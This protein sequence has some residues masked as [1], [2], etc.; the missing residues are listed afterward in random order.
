MGMRVEDLLRHFLTRAAP[1]AAGY[2]GGQVAGE[3][4]KR[5]R[6]E[7]ATATAREEADRQRR[8]ERESA[9]DRRRAQQDQTEAEKR[10]YEAANPIIGPNG[11]RFSTRQ[12]LEEFIRSQA[13]INASVSAAH[14]A[15]PSATESATASN[16]ALARARAAAMGSAKNLYTA[17]SGATPAYVRQQLRAQYPNLPEGE[18]QG[19]ALEAHAWANKERENLPSNPRRPAAARPSNDIDL[20]APRAP[21]RPRRIGG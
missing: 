4:I 10:A 9:D 19:I 20:N 21:A 12:A 14:R 11:N 5:E 8:I 16:Q 18:I 3:E 13:E 17:G 15:P 7:K 6:T 1:M 2:A